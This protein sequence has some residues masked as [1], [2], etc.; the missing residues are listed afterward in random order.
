[1][2]IRYKDSLERRESDRVTLI[3]N[4]KKEYVDDETQKRFLDNF[5]EAYGE[6]MLRWRRK[7]E[8]YTEKLSG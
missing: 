3:L 2:L 1:M 4:M 8:E 5:D 6:D 7:I